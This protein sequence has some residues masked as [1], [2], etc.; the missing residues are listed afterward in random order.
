MKLQQLLDENQT[1]NILL[2][3]G[4][5]NSLA[6]DFAEFE[7]DDF[8]GDLVDQLKHSV[9][10]EAADKRKW[11]MTDSDENDCKMN[12]SSESAIDTIDG[13]AHLDEKLR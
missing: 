7:G 4:E 5:Q 1:A 10:V 11:N 6:A 2:C 12:R 8:H 9:R 3:L 13:D